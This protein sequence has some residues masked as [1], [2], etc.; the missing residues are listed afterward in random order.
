M[1]VS[2]SLPEEVVKA[3]DEIVN[4]RGSLSRNRSSLIAA[5]LEDF[6]A[7]NYPEDYREPAKGKAVG[8]TV[9]S[10]LEARFRMRSPRLR[11]RAIDTEWIEVR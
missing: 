6:L 7:R 9:L 3:I 11:G 4:R 5:A 1:K 8:P 10:Y 2:V